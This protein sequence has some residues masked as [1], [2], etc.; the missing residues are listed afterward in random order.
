MRFF[1]RKP[2]GV[3]TGGQFA[4]SAR[5]ESTATLGA[6]AETADGIQSG[7]TWTF[8]P[9][10]PGYDESAHDLNTPAEAIQAA[11]EAVIAE[12]GTEPNARVEDSEMGV[13]IEQNRRDREASER[14]QRH[15]ESVP[16]PPA[17]PMSAD[18]I[19]Q[20]MNRPPSGASL[21][22]PHG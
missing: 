15:P 14:W 20:N 18:T 16:S 3:P 10:D 2:K 11:R 7:E 5:D 4:T 12:H 22:N 6:L 17:R 1:N 13:L 19:D 9:G 8:R 21:F